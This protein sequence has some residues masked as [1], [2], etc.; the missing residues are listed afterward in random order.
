M[1]KHRLYTPFV[2]TLACIGLVPVHAAPPKDAQRPAAVKKSVAMIIA[3]ENF[4]DEELRQPLKIFRDAG[5]SVT[6]F[7]KSVKP[8]KGMLGFSCTPDKP[9]SAL[10]VA[11]FD[12]IV[13]VGGSGAKTYWDDPLSHGICKAAVAQHKVLAAICIAPVILA[14]A[15][16][17]EGKKAT[18]WPATK[19]KLSAKGAGYV[20]Q[21]VVT[22]GRIVTADGPR[23]AAPFARAILKLLGV[24][25]AK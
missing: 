6:V 10:D 2:L 7:S 23:S 17:L 8:A 9:L 24:P 18:V 21:P 20:S 15:G 1:N 19:N 5:L 25:R 12:A 16:V 11:S 22:D 14:R 4:R 13:F 3:P